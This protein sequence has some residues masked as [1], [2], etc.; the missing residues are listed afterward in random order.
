ML[1]DYDVNSL[2]PN[3]MKNNPMPVG[4]PVPFEGDIRKVVPDAFGFFYCKITS[5]EY[6]EHPILQKRINT[7]EGPRTIAGLGSWEG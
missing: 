7:K 3:A 2:Y 1:F 5:P 4:K 6:L